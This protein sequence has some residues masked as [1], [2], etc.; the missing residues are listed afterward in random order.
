[1]RRLVLAAAVATVCAGVPQ[2]LNATQAAGP[3]DRLDLD[4]YW[5]YEVVSDPQQLRFGPDG[6]IEP[7]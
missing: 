6:S 3:S 2:G 4:L 7:F 1:M 5:E